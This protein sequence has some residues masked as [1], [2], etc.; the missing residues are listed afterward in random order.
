MVNQVADASV[1][2]DLSQ[3][4]YSI[5]GFYKPDPENTGGLAVPGASRLTVDPSVIHVNVPIHSLESYKAVPV[6]AT[7]VGQPRAGFGVVGV[8]VEP[9]LITASGYPQTLARLTS[10]GTRALSIAHHG[11]GRLKWRVALSLPIGVTT[12]TR[13]VTVT[14]QLAAVS[15]STSIEIGIMPANL[16][17]GLVERMHPASVLVTVL[18]PSSA[19]THA[20]AGIRAT[21]D[22]STYGIG[23]YV[24]R[25]EITVPKGLRIEAI[26]PSTVTAVIQAPN[27]VS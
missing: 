18:G 2:V 13:K 3:V 14:A 9:P 20:A 25:P 4:R 15:A 11:A 8:T 1:F 6:I 22:L 24:V 10:V 19:L 23:T 17:S 7:L 27:P 12:H 5:D 21:V 16:A 26:F